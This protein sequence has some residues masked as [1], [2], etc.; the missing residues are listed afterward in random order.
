MI[1]KKR[2]IRKM[3]G[4]ATCGGGGRKKRRGAGNRGG[5]GLAGSGR[6]K[7]KWDWV[8][9]NLKDHIGKHGFKNPTSKDKKALN[10]FYFENSLERL[11]EGGIA[12]SEKGMILIDT[13]RLGISKV[14]G[15]GRLTHKFKIMA[16]EFSES[17]KK[18]IKKSGGE[19]I[20][21]P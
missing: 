20:V 14:L 15:S 3:R 2:K 7:T 12:S 21:V 10:L 5:R 6:K 8:R 18:K 4:S 1:R 16:R 19:A 13:R 9:L 17:A 11:I